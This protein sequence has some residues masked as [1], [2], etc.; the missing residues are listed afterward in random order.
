M[1]TRSSTEISLTLTGNGEQ[2]DLHNAH[3]SP[4]KDS[5]NSRMSH[6]DPRH[7]AVM[8][9]LIVLLCYVVVGALMFS[10]A[11]ITPYS[12]TDSYTDL[13]QAIQ[14]SLYGYY[15]QLVTYGRP[16]Y[17]LLAQ[18]AFSPMSSI[19]DLRYLRL[20]AVI[21]TGLLAWTFY[22]ALRL[23]GIRQQYAIVL[24]LLI[25]TTPPYEVYVGWDDCFCFPYAAVL[26]G[27]AL[28][29]ANSAITKRSSRQGW[30]RGGISL[31]LL[32][33]AMM[34]YQPAAMVFVVFV[35]IVL[36]CRKASL[37]ST[38]LR[39]LVYCSMLMI[40]LGIDFI[41]AKTLPVLLYGA[42]LAG[43]RTQ[44]VT[45]I[46]AKAGWFFQEPLP[47]AL[48]LW[49]LLP[50]VSIA[51]FVGVFSF[52]GLFLFLRGKL[53]ER[54][55]KLLIA[56]VL[57]PLSYLPNLIVEESW[58]SYRT[59]AALT[60][61]IALYVGLAL[62]GFFHSSRLQMESLRIQIGPLKIQRPFIRVQPGALATTILLVVVIFGGLVAARNVTRYFVLPQE[63]ELSFIVSQLNTG[64]LAT[65]KRIYVIPCSW[66]DSI[67]PVVR[68]DEFGLASCSQP[69]APGP[70]VYLVLRELAPAKADIPIVVASPGDVS[71]PPDGSIVIDMRL[72]RMYRFAEP[73]YR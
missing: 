37:R 57:V 19:G 6:L 70:M 14:G 10:V 34:I 23:A 44:L 49:N 69:W 71:S 8:Q 16:V 54:L 63:Q 25:C 43:S 45:D 50:K 46:P 27:A 32:V 33:M 55:S 58:A 64:S 59:Q 56:V 5:L 9:E 35:A 60:A 28:I 1:E 51:V 62:L 47:D 68:Y 17:A 52:A 67:S 24:P 26:A 20:I 36:F 72:L 3:S 65:V 66:S 48:N 31:V 41:A 61:L 2:I 11:L 18:M 39:F 4:L 13:A 21:G 15:V 30:I 73:Q 38:L 12:F 22:K 40:A 29:L 53:I 7:R 42:P